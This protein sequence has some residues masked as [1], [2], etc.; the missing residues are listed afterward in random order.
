MENVNPALSL[1]SQLM[2]V[3]KNYTIIKEVASQP[4][5]VFIKERIIK[6][7]SFYTKKKN[8]DEKEEDIELVLYGITLYI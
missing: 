1:L 8:Q 4:Q 6:M 5:N 3:F 7:L 2:K